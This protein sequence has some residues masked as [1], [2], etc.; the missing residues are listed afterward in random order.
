MPVSP[1]TAKASTL[2]F[3]EE[4]CNQ[5]KFEDHAKY[6]APDFISHHGPHTA[7]GA[8]AFVK[9]FQYA[10]PNFMPQF[11]MKVLR[12][13]ADAQT[14]WVWSEISGLK[15]GS[16]KESVDIFTYDADS[17]LLKEKWDVQTPPSSAQ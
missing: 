16:T 9:G 13:V 6:L 15:D 10:I 7:N 4:V 5:R 1:E 11:H 3:V 12:A 8:E 14:V 17:G 2:A